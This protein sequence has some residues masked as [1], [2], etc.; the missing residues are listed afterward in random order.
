MNR[1][2]RGSGTWRALVV[3][4]LVWAGC[5]HEKDDSAASGPAPKAGKVTVK[6]L[7]TFDHAKVAE[8]AADFARCVRE[9]EAQLGRASRVDGNEHWW[10]ATAGDECHAYVLVGDGAGKMA[11][12]KGPYE[13]GPD[14]AA[15]C[16][17]IAG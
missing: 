16:R 10:A 1:H 4:A 6:R 7:E 13:V 5:D 9:A 2:T 12:S 17:E 8:H 14:E 15:H 3:A 11:E